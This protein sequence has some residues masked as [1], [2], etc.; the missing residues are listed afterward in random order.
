MAAS[1]EDEAV[2]G[3]LGLLMLIISFLER[4]RAAFGALGIY[5]LPRS[6][7]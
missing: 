4:A 7:I 1:P 6:T 3:P 5:V 2:D